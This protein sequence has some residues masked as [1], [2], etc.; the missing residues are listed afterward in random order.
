MSLKQPLLVWYLKYSLAGRPIW[1]PTPTTKR[2][3]SMVSWH[4]S[5]LSMI[6][7]HFDPVTRTPWGNGCQFL[8]S[9]DQQPASAECTPGSLPVGIMATS[10]G[11]PAEEAKGCTCFVG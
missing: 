1:P 10:I 4:S 3:R 7:A 2:A 8:L 9:T 11:Q 5:R 6:S